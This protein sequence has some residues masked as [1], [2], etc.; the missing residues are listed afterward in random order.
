[1]PVQ[2]IAVVSPCN[3]SMDNSGIRI[4]EIGAQNGQ[5][6]TPGGNQPADSSHAE[7]DQ[8]FLALN[9]DTNIV[10]DIALSDAAVGANIN[11]HVVAD[12]VIIGDMNSDSL[13]D[14]TGKHSDSGTDGHVHVQVVRPR[15]GTPSNGN[16]DI[17][18][19]T[20][21][22]SEKRSQTRNIGKSSKKEKPTPLKKKDSGTQVCVKIEYC[23][24]FDVFCR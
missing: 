17:S 4:A 5:N 6:V 9:C 23:H 2:Q 14:D 15:T 12:T 10:N 20:L 18:N 3:N 1:M 22:N 13:S 16:S 19:G 7:S 21:P 11:T 24:L 8:N